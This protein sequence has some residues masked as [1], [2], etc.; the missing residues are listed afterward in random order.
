MTS[1]PGRNDSCPCGSGLKYKHCCLKKKRA[2]NNS[3][4]ANTQNPVSGLPN[5]GMSYPENFNEYIIQHAAE[6]E[7]FKKSFLEKGLDIDA[8]M[9]KL[10]SR[11]KLK[12]MSTNDIIVKLGSMNINFDIDQFKKQVEGYV[13]ACDLAEDH[14]YDDIVLVNNLDEDFVWLAIVELWSRIM[15]DCLNKEMIDDMM[16]EGYVCLEKRIVDE[17]MEKWDNAWNMIKD[18]VPSDITSVEV[19]DEFI[20]MMQCIFNWCQDFE[21]ELY[22]AGL[23]N[24]A[25]FTKRIQFSHDLCQTFPDSDNSIIHNMLRAEAE[26]YASL[27]D[28][29]TADRLFKELIERFPYNVW[30]YIGWGDMY[31][32]KLGVPEDS[33]KAREIYN[34]ALLECDCEIDVVEERLASLEKDIRNCNEIT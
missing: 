11:D 18:I 19:A 33:D 10:W 12:K 3:A 1:K 23:G 25:Y 16:Q 28:I 30:G 26:S 32:F 7:A 29:T 22:N 17:A 14:Y 5:T 27:G 4:T 8:L 34:R 2:E 15:P 21:M 6:F 24:S 13:C 31:A 20:P 9:D